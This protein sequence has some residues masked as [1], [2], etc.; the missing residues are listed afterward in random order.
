MRVVGAESALLE[1][2]ASSR[3]GVAQTRVPSLPSD[4]TDLDAHSWV[5]VYFNGIGWVPFDPTP[6]AAPAESQSDGSGAGSAAPG[7]GGIS[8]K[9]L[10]AEFGERALPAREP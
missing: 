5:E 4:V 2:F 1:R 6:S 10:E 9:D 3:S 8:A 7:G